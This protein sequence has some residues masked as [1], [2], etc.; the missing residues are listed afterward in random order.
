[1]LSTRIRTFC[2]IVVTM[3][4]AAAAHAQVRPYVGFAY[5]AGGQQGTTF[6]VT[7][8]GQTMDD[9]DSAIVTGAGVTAKVVEYY[10]PLGPIEIQVLNE[11]LRDL[12]K[13]VRAKSSAVATL[14][15][16]G[17]GNNAMD[18]AMSGNAMTSGMDAM[19][20]PATKA[21]GAAGVDEDSL[22]IARLERRIA[23]YVQRP[24]SVAIAGLAVIEVTIA[25]DATPGERELRVATPRG[26]SN[27]VVFHVGQLPEICRKP[28]TTS[29]FQVL[30]KEELALRK[31]PPDD[32]ED[33]ITLP[34]TVNGQVASGEVN[35]YRFEARKGQRLVITTQARQLIPY[36]A[37]AVPGWFQPVLALYDG[38]GKEIA[39]DDDYRFKP[40]PVILFQVP[41]DGEYVFAIYDGIYRGR[42]DFVYRVSIGELPFVTSIFPLGAQAGS[43]PTIKMKGWNLEGARIAPPP[44]DAAP[45]VYSLT[46][47][48]NGLISNR[49]TFALDALPEMVEAEPN[50]TQPRAQKVSMPVMI[51][52]RINR[53]DDWDVYRIAGHAGETIV[54][55]VYARRLDS[56]LDSVLKVTDAEGKLIAYSDDREDLGA[57]VNT[58][59]ADSYLM[60]KLP[61][62]GTYFVHVGDVDRSGG[63]EY[64]YRLR[65]S[66]PRPDFALRVVPSSLA[67]RSKN[68]NAVTVYAIRKD[69]FA[70]PIKL[71]LRNPPA[72]FS[73]MSSSSWL[74]PKQES[75]RFTV[76]TDLAA[77]D[78]P[79]SL[80][81][82]GR[83]KL[84]GREI[85]RKAVPAEDRMQAFLWRHLVPANSLPSLVFNPS[86]EPTLRRTPPPR[87][88]KIEPGKTEVAKTEP[89]KPLEAGKPADP[90]APKPK[91]TKQQVLGRLR[92][93]KL[94]YAE[95][96]L[97]DEFYDEKV[98]ECE[99]AL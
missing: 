53:T 31:R 76:K 59:H 34:C 32:V 42:E 62:D 21:A 23:T 57:G 41:K 54:A 78:E 28:M 1:M 80:V 48:C 30:G 55:E 89:N 27:P 79:V 7:L 96:L 50:N 45:G 85:V 16:G 86:I 65:I 26:I 11:Q 94:L 15:K 88:V 39:Y 40:D 33:R 14:A 83:A 92:Q 10:R 74:S 12:R 9:V 75:V 84:N 5:P 18:A 73:A 29:H 38:N 52:G 49:V 68:S 43:T 60:A 67:F 4:M 17:P 3:A 71:G 8:G 35:R 51:N 87:P 64:D 20:N 6:R 61:A 82:E 90:N 63:E 91:F 95:G 58:H 98:S 37:D 2:G 97:T 72:G 77:S 70:E 24:A 69:G 25:A 66:A 36:I 47:H 81:V 13:A 22:R 46:A 19:D 56:P 44:K 93:L 99:A